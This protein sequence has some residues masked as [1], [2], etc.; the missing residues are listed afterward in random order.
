MQLYVIAIIT[1]MLISGAANT[2]LTKLQNSEC[3]ADCDGEKPVLYEQPIWQTL[4]MFIGE[5]ACLLVYSAAFWADKRR[6]ARESLNGVTSTGGFVGEALLG[7]SGQADT[8][9][10]DSRSP[11]HGTSN[12]LLWI[13][14]ACDMTATVLMMA[15]F[16]AGVPPSVY[17]M[18]RGAVVI[19]T[20][21]AS[22]LFLGRRLPMYKWLALLAVFVGVAIVGLSSVLFP[23]PGEEI[24]L[25]GGVLLGLI[26]IMAAQIFA[27]GLF[28]TEEKILS[29]Y[30]AAPLKC[31]GLEG[32]FGFIT[33]CVLLLILHFSVGVQKGNEG[34]M[35]DA[36]AGFKQSWVQNDT[37]RYTNVA[38]ALTI[39]IFNFCGLTVTSLLSATSRS[40]LDT[41][42]TIIVWAF[43]LSVGWET[44]RTEAFVLELAG[45]LVLVGGTFVF[46]DA[47][48]CLR[49]SSGSAE[50]NAEEPEPHG[51]PN[52]V[53][54]HSVVGPLE[55]EEMTLKKSFQ[56]PPVEKEMRA[57]TTAGTS[58][59]PSTNPD[60]AADLS[61]QSRQRQ[62]L[63][64]GMPVSHP[65]SS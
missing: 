17:Q 62:A 42:R 48:P 43:S 16:A 10:V 14:A 44:F 64:Q 65:G 3:V 58:P 20:G 27:A 47:I 6:A 22:V 28:V 51:E 34:S 15:G 37:I 35:Y 18:L 56:P 25:K 33:V 54:T 12:L 23:A 1:L 40:T 32:T 52:P 46:N 24:S 19:F 21:V 53:D 60:A 41:C 57:P 2:L 63:L 45:F 8:D 59:P 29:K 11:L 5:F 9:S 50:G 13:P 31:V 4:V 49:F 55:G 7:R 26:L 38:C 39:A 61:P 30:K 36:V